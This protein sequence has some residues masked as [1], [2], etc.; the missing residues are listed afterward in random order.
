MRSLTILMKNVHQCHARFRLSEL[1][2]KNT[3]YKVKINTFTNY[4]LTYQKV[5]MSKA[6]WPF[7]SML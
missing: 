5:E 1:G 4:S 6:V 2:I 3:A 7:K